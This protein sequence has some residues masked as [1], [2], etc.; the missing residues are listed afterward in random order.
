MKK[1]LFVISCLDSG[2]VSK[3]L[4]NLLNVIDTKRYEV[5]L[6]V[7]NKNGFSH[8]EIPPEINV[9]NTETMREGW[10]E[11]TFLVIMFRAFRFLVSRF[12]RCLGAL[13]Y[14]KIIPKIKK[15]YDVA[16]DYNGQMILYYVVDKVSADIK[17]SFFHSDYEK[18]RYYERLDRK[19]YQFVDTIFTVSEKCVVSMKRIFPEYS[20][21]IMLMENLLNP[22][23]LEKASE[24]IIPDSIFDDEFSILTVGHVGEN[25]GTS[26][27]IKAAKILKESG[28][29]FKWYFIGSNPR[30]TYYVNI[31]EKCGVKNEIVFLGLRKNP[32]PY[33]RQCSLFVLPSKFEGKSIALDEAKLL[34][35]PI[36]VT[37]F[38]TA[39]DQFEN[40]VTASICDMTPFALARCILELARNSNLRDRYIENLARRVRD[41]SGDILI[42][43]RA[44]ERN[45]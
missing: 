15:H 21:K 28:L 9:L 18:W 4:L 8:S 12:S 42:L 33:I 29:F 39:I 34:K 45:E 16:I 10:R 6:F 25:K 35:K 36:V 17:I 41:N 14:S 7:V 19:Y 3:S 2:G 22:Q 1:I 37:N 38:S 27:A 31:A 24:E 23:V 11:N 43:Y 30:R 40:G 32:Y 5:D 44:F 13:I 26:L 20:E